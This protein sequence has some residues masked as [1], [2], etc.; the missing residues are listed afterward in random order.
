MNYVFLP[1]ASRWLHELEYLRQATEAEYSHILAK[2]STGSNMHA[3]NNACKWYT[4]S[5]SVGVILLISIMRRKHVR[6]CKTRTCIW[7][8][9]PAV[10]FET[11]QQASFL[12]L[13]LWFWVNRLRRQERA[14]WSMMH[15]R[16]KGRLN[17]TSKM[18]S[19]NCIITK[20]K[21][22][23]PVMTEINYKMQHKWTKDYLYPSKSKAGSWN[24]N[25]CFTWIK[26]LTKKDVSSSSSLGQQG[27]RVSN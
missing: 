20:Q 3:V 22:L 7:S 25:R 18:N 27:N 5:I 14:W 8:L 19:L 12:M 24:I 6:I 16:T 23:M 4:Q 2:C 13:F 21:L 10:I 17:E 1:S 15:C 9:L 26:M 11:V